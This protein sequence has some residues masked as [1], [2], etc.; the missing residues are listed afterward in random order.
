[1]ITDQAPAGGRARGGARTE[2]RP[3]R[4]WAQSLTLD[5]VFSRVARRRPAGI[6][7]REGAVGLSYGKAELRSAQLATALVRGGVQLGDPVIVHCDDH[8]QAVVAQLAVLKAGGV[9]VPVPPEVSGPGLER[10]ADISGA[11][12]VVCGPAG[13]SAW[14]SGS[15]LVVLDADTWGKVRVLR[16]DPSLPRSGP[17]DPAY[18]LIADEDGPDASGQLIDHRAWQFSMAARIQQV[19]VA[20]GA[21]TVRE[22]PTGP[23][24]ISAMWWA[25][26]CGGTLHTPPR[27]GELVRS[28]AWSGTAVAVFSPEEYAP[29]LEAVALTPEAVGPR[30]VVLVGGP[31]P[32]ELVERHFQVVPTTRLRAE[33]APAGG[34]MPW[35]AMEFSLLEGTKLPEFTVGSP[36]PNVHVQ[37]L[38][39]EG[40]VL[41]PGRIGEVC[42]AGPALPFDSVRAVG[43][44]V[45]EADGG[46]MLRSA[47]M[48]RWRT[49]GTLEIT[50]TCAA[51]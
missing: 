8:R 33:F 30:A 24:T 39:P 45:P 4:P 11:Q 46:L 48:G 7:V 43:R 20:D 18:L 36:M 40:A 29:V 26:A 1:M 10:I 49:D 50:G 32:R 12:A 22:R 19:G 17:M 16:A 5:A 34:A 31:C 23:R 15:P 9:C 41:P 3:A 47:R 2:E 25:F 44:E 27:A 28:L 42:A 35:T 14:R 13:R 37:V 6:A 38:G 51:R 21:V